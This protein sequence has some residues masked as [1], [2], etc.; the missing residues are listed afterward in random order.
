VTT[1]SDVEAR[2]RYRAVVERVD[3]IWRTNAR[4]A[5]RTTE[6]DACRL[7]SRQL[8]G[9]RR[10]YWGAVRQLRALGERL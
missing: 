2:A 5:L 1:I 9:L 4:G 6:G 8:I 3:L 7:S 10:V